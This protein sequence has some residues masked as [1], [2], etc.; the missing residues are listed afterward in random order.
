MRDEEQYT[1]AQAI[2]EPTSVLAIVAFVIV[3]AMYGYFAAIH[4]A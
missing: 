2:R 1:L 3:L 4:M